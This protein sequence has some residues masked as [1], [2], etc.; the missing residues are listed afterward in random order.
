MKDEGATKEQLISE[1]V[2]LRQRI[3][4]LEA[5]EADRKRAEEALQES[6]KDTAFW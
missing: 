3:A 2:E 1:S 6:E 4:E 5:S